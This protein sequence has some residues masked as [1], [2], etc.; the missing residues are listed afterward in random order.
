MNQAQHILTGRGRRSGWAARP[1]VT[2]VSGLLL[3]LSVVLGSV[4]VGAQGQSAGG[5]GGETVTSKAIPAAR[6][7]KKVAVITIAEGIDRYTVYAVKQRLEDA[8]AGGAEAVVFELDTPGGELNSMLALCQLIKGSSVPNT[9]AWINPDAYSAGAVVALA[10]REIIA[11]DNATMG[12]ALPIAVDLFGMLN[13]LPDAE[14]QKLLVPVL[15]EVTNSARL[16]GHD[17]MLVQGIVST[18]V[19]LWLVER[20]DEPLRRAFITRGEYRAVFGQ[21]PPEGMTPDIASVGERPDAP[22]QGDGNT[23][24]IPPDQ[25][26]T[27]D[28]SV[29]ENAA[30]PAPAA[31]K[32]SGDPAKA[33]SPAESIWP[34][35]AEAVSDAMEHVTNRPNFADPAE[36]GKWRLVKYI[37]TGRGLVTLKTEQLVEYGLATETVNSDD[38]L[39]AYFGANELVRMEPSWSVGMVR[40]L[41]NPLIRGLLIVVML[42]GLFIEMVHPGLILPGSVAACALV[43]LLMPP[44]L[45]D[46]ATWWEI[47]AIL[48]GL[49]LL[50]LELFVIPGFGVV[51]AAGVLLLFGGLIGTF[52]GPGALFTGDEQGNSDLITGLTTLLLS[53]IVAGVSIYFVSKNFGSLPIMRKLILTTRHGDKFDD[54]DNAIAHDSSTLLGSLGDEDGAMLKVG[55]M[56][57]VATTLRPSG[58]INVMDRLY[59]VVSEG[60]II[61]VGTMV[62]VVSAD[63]FRIGV[64]V[65]DDLSGDG[66]IRGDQGGSA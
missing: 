36:Q 14:R 61:P 30:T 65:A 13:E 6:A 43:A 41:T 32:P 10:C 56:G 3:M 59:D 29:D 39:K 7:A 42:L 31:A 1:V 55:T 21:D 60:G 54:D 34:E 49:V 53:G 23:P 48:V 12:D 4:R 64:E 26:A 19:E 66:G 38:D 58:K 37:S 35:T 44:A 15:V 52:V 22:K 40:F 27:E 2:W 33:F 62:R 20:A 47:A 25:P 17:E 11:A 57:M 8:V 45:V 9:V 5:G 18:G 28:E 50:G 24:P 16:R 51:G 46:L 63:R